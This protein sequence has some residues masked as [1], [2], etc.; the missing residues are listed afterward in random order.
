MEYNVNDYI[1][2][3]YNECDK[4]YIN[5]IID[6][7]ERNYKNVMRFL[8][9]SKL[10][11]ELIIKF[12]DD[13]SKFCE[14]L[15]NITGLETPFW[16]IASSI[17]NK[18]DSISRIDSLSLKEIRKIDYHKDETIE[19]LKKTILHEFIHI[20][21]IDFCNYTYPKELWI[22]EGLATYFSKQYNNAKL[23]ATLESI[24]NNDYVEYEN[25]RFLFDKLF[26]FYNKNQILE[27]L[28]GKNS[29]LILDDI[30]KKI[31]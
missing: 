22:S 17:N 7:F 25:Y 28:N 31:I 16:M 24:K 9:L 6:Y 11:K 14:K 18:N 15:K 21:H 27:V 19:D 5:E 1:K 13:S 30:Y 3:I 26:E 20:C 10:E 29:D 4:V 8:N 2:I 23:T 12:W